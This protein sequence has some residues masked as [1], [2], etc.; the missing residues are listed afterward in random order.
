MP[1]LCG[2]DGFTVPQ[3][4]MSTLY[5]IQRIDSVLHRILHRTRI[6]QPIRL[7]RREVQ[8]GSFRFSDL[9]PDPGLSYLGSACLW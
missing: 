5:R 1:Q 2:L 4:N 9:L 8:V 7:E 3:Q 6:Q